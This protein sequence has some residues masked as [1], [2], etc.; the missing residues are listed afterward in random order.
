MVTIVC[1]IVGFLWA[2]Q[3]GIMYN[4]GEAEGLGDLPEKASPIIHVLAILFTSLL[5]AIS[6]VATNWTTKEIQYQRAVEN[7]MGEYTKKG[8]R[9]ID[10]KA[11]FIISGANIVK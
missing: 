10:S 2:I 7:G 1:M 3:L 4:L 9:I 8:E 5:W 6:M 11:E